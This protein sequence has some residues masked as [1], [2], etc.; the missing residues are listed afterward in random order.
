M[1]RPL[2]VIKYHPDSYPHAN[3]KRLLPG[4][5]RDVLELAAVAVVGDDI[6]FARLLHTKNRAIDLPGQVKRH[7]LARGGAFGQVWTLFYSKRSK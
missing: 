1:P 4:V 5:Q 7:L 2:G 3:G 6:E